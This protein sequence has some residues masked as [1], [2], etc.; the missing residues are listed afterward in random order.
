MLSPCVFVLFVRSICWPV[1]NEHF[2]AMC[3]FVNNA[4]ELSLLIDL[5]CVKYLMAKSNT[6]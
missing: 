1:D 6:V 2:I 4:I 5:T 3:P